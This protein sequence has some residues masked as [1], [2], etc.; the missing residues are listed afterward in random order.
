MSRSRS[1]KQPP[2]YAFSD[3]QVE[4]FS[5]IQ[6]NDLLDSQSPIVSHSEALYFD[7]HPKQVSHPR[8]VLSSSTLYSPT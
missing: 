7:A 1:L 6:I 8:T 3:A 2:I 5:T 4:D